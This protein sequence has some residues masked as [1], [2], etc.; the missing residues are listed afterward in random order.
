MGITYFALVSALGFMRGTVRT[1]SVRDA[2]SGG[3]LLGVLIELP[4]ML[5]AAR[6]LCHAVVCRLAVATAVAA[7]A[8]PWLWQPSI[9]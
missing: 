4:I 8:V 5:W 6:C 3:R 7:P 9:T 2:P 1:L